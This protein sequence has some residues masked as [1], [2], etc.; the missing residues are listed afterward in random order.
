MKLRKI[1]VGT[2]MILAVG[3]GSVG[4]A[5]YADPTPATALYV[6]QANKA[7]SDTGSGTSAA[8][9]CTIQAAANVAS[10]GQTVVVDPGT[11]NEDYN[12]SVQITRSGTPG[13]PITFEAGLPWNGYTPQVVVG[14]IGTQ[15]LQT[16]FTLSGVHDVVI[17]G[18][19]IEGAKSESVAVADSSDITVD[20][21]GF[22]IGGVEEISPIGVDVTGASND[23]TVSRSVF[24]TSGDA[25][26]IGSGVTNAIVS[27]NRFNDSFDGQEVSA[28][29]ATGTAITSNTWF[30]ACNT[31]VAVADSSA[32][33]I[34]NNLVDDGCAA[35]STK[36][37]ITV[38]SGSAPSTSLDYN[39][40]YRTSTGPVYSWAGSVYDTAT[41]FNKATGQGAHDLNVNPGT[42]FP[43]TAAVNSADANAPGEL[44]TDI[45]DNPRTDDP[46]VPLTGTGVG[47]YDRGAVQ[48]QDPLSV[49][50]TL[51]AWQAPTGGVVTATIATS[52]PWSSA[53]T[54]S[55]DFGDGSA[56]T[57]TLSTTTHAYSAPGVYQVT[58]TM[59]D[60]AGTA[61]TATQSITVVP[62]AALDAN[63]TATLSGAL[64]VQLQ[65]ETTDSW[66]MTL[67]S[68]DFGDGTPA[69]D[70]IGVDR[71]QFHTYAQLGTYTITATYADAG[72]NTAAVSK[73]ITTVGSDF[74]VY[75]P[76]RL[77]DTRFGTG[78]GGKVAKVP[79]QGI[80]K[81]QIAGNGSIP[82]G[83]TAVALNLTATDTT[84]SGFV[85]AYADGASTPDVSNLNY[86][87]GRSV[88]NAV[89]VPVGGDG[90]IDLFNGGDGAGSID[91][92]ADVTGYFTQAV[93]DGYTALSP[94]RLLDTRDGTGAAEAK[95]AAGKAV[96]LTIVG[97]DGGSLPA[98][99]ITA[100]ALNVITTDTTGSGFISAYPFGS[101]VPISSN[102]NYT[103]GQTVANAVIVPVGLDGKVELYNGGDSA[104]SVDLIADVAGYFSAGGASAYVPVTPARLLDTRDTVAVA[105]DGEV[106]VAPLPS[107]P[108]AGYAPTA[109]VLNTTV[110][111]PTGSGFITVFP[112][113]TALPNASTVNYTPNLTIANLTL[114]SPGDAE[115]APVDFYN[116]GDKAGSTD[117]VVD[118]FGYFS[119]S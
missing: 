7:C 48:L 30:S 9:F 66:N 3:S 67:M 98:S 18:F 82:A 59:T 112:A 77:L 78:T 43:S 113:G 104:G 60:A 72:G 73:T 94:D 51:S 50:L 100:V 92:I 86:T 41:A 61:R 107:L 54:G 65:D 116:G 31:A 85:T 42:T 88:P 52:N 29:G 53:L 39:I 49:G 68:I 84:G 89:I 1:A 117:L 36:P 11:P 25:V 80:V 99:G 19:A 58:V 10:A 17:R 12:E 115:G 74:T 46:L 97:A 91:L 70:W 90:K 57:S 62:P 32:T 56:P 95:I 33:T 47:Y 110:T 8:P 101:P 69:Q 15:V 26:S 45:L 64:S 83:V 102:L 4:A 21:I 27:T 108:N 34:E 118:V 75:G 35:A 79:A 20:H 63:F 76:A 40:P 38:D 114:V 14:P 23:V 6:D 105:R 28:D 109:Y 119:A 22:G 81:L 87:A 24:E 106:A 5:A 16:G 93:G 55:V 44:P 111:Q 71:Q 37:V 2:A 13:D 103:P 96:T